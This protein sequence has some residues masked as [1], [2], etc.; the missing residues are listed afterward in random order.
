M[1]VTHIST[2]IEET[3]IFCN[4]CGEE[5]WAELEKIKHLEESMKVR[6]TVKQ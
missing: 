5:F 2:R 1:F 3:R 6:K 4:L